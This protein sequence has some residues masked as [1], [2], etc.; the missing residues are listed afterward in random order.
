MAEESIA[1]Y[2][3]VVVTCFADVI[4]ILI[5]VNIHLPL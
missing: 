3:S 1:I 4:R 5:S 2:Q